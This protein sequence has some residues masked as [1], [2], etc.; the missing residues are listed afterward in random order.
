MGGSGAQMADLRIV[1]AMLISTSVFTSAVGLA[2]PDPARLFDA[3]LQAPAEAPQPTAFQSNFLDS[4][5]VRIRYVDQ[6]Q[7]PPVVLIHGYTGNLERHWINPG[8]FTEL[9]R[10]HRV[11]ALDCR[12]HGKSDKPH[13]PGSYGVEMGKDI[14]KLLD[15][16]KISRAHI[17]GF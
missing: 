3:D 9:A 2:P 8:V 13:S 6:G 10:D 15:H 11:I 12:G 4:N 16:L 17:V 5:G 14:V 1:I 7:G